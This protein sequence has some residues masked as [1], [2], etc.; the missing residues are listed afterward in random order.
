LAAST[1]NAFT[2]PLPTTLPA[3]A[4][5]SVSVIGSTTTLLAPLFYVSPG[6]INFQLPFEVTDATVNLVVNTGGTNSAPLSLSVA[7]TSPGIFIVDPNSGQGAILHSSYA[8]VS[9]ASPANVGEVVLIYCTGLGAVNP[10]LLSGTA[11]PSNGTLYTA[12]TPT[13]S[14]G[15]SNAFVSFA[16]LAPGFV[17]L[18]QINAVVPNVPAGSSVPVTLNAGSSVPSNTVIMQ[19]AQQ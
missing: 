15:G 18:Y 11:T 17:G 3:S 2:L 8:L 14:I 4:G 9:A 13:V 7:S 6:Q 1:E 19:V 10:P 16:G 12:S 5:T